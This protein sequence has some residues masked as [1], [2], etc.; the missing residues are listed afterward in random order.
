MYAVGY[1]LTF[2]FFEAQSIFEEIAE[3]TGLGDFLSNQLIGFVIRF[4]TDSVINMVM[5][6]MWPVYIVQLY[7]PFGAI[8]LGIA[9]IAFPKYWKKPIEKILFDE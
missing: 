5:A 9:F 4:A 7:P 2:L 1:I 8:A 6:L 3:S